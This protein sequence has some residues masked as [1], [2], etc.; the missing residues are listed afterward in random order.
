M[1]CNFSF[2][3]KN[4]NAFVLAGLVVWCIVLYSLPLGSPYFHFDDKIS[5][6]TNDV[7]KQL[8]VDQLFEVFNTRFLVGLSFAVNYA[9][10]GMYPFSHRLINILIHVFN[11]FLV[12]LLVRTIL[13]LPVVKAKSGAQYA[14]IFASLLFLSHP[15]QTETVNFITQRFVLLGSFFYLL[16]V[17]LFMQFRLHSQIKYLV[18]ALGSALSAMFCK[19]FTVT[20]PL[21]LAL[22]DIYFLSD[23]RESRGKRFKFLI[24]FLLM[25]CV[26]PFT[27]LKT[28]TKTTGAASIASYNLIQDAGGRVIKKEVDIT[29]AQGV[30]I[31]RREYFL[32]QLNVV[33]TYLRLLVL[34]IHQNIDYDYPISHKLDLRTILSGMFLFLF[35]S[36][37]IFIYKKER[38]ISFCIMWFFLALSV[39]SS[40]IPIAHVIAEYRLYLASFGF[41][42][43]VAYLLTR[44]HL[45]SFVPALIILLIA[46]GMTWKRNDIWADEIKLWRD[47]VNK[48][49]F[50][51]RPYINLAGAYL[52]DQQ[53]AKALP[54]LVEAIAIDP[55]SAVAY[56]NLA[57][58]YQD[59]DD[60]QNALFYALKAA[61]L[62]STNAVYQQKVGFI[63][64]KEKDFLSAI[65]YYANALNIKPNE[66][67]AREYL[68]IVFAYYAAEK[69]REKALQ[70][71]NLL[72]IQHFD[73]SANYLRSLIK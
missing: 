59:L 8:D 38:L 37:G 17:L 16:T 65:K 45:R 28:S 63:Y 29:K 64:W 23:L 19:E 35:L 41:V 14:P 4:I 33:R 2:I 60:R 1:I 52:I 11:A 21:M 9:L 46:S 51:Q 43:G 72:E 10:G 25:I 40:F 70:Y 49:P 34:P 26:I 55:S 24:P 3:Q 66:Y 68:K 73:D 22:C 53:Y 69:N 15:I 12:Y 57:C 20:L 44:L 6:E 31:T 71:A 54:L 56:F 27:L 67:N 18:G 58:V 7:I 62:E 47:T 5:I 32:T 61:E 42:L 48:S 36:A 30:K 50:K 39:E 13:G